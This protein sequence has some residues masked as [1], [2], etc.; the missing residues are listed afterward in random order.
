MRCIFF[1]IRT[2][3]FDHVPHKHELFA[4]PRSYIWKATQSVLCSFE[5]NASLPKSLRLDN[6]KSTVIVSLVVNLE[7]PHVYRT[8]PLNLFSREKTRR[9]S[10]IFTKRQIGRGL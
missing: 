8:K 10:Q 5:K 1:I 2:D 7:A 3:I 6:D 4:V 9:Y